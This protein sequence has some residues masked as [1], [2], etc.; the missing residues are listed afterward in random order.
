MSSYSLA[1]FASDRSFSVKLSPDW[2]YLTSLSDW[3]VGRGGEP[4]IDD[5][6]AGIVVKVEVELFREAIRVLRIRQHR[7]GS[8]S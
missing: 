3:N 8:S 2:M 6:H 5:Q 7:A 1:A 4:V